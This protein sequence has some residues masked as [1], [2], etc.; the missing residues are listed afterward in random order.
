MTT[1]ELRLTTPSDL[2]RRVAEKA[3]D[4]VAGGPGRLK[5]VALLAGVLALAAA[6]QGAVSAVSKQLETAFS[7]SNTQFG[8]ILSVVTF[9]GAIGTIPLGVLVDRTR[10]RR[11]LIV[12]I[13]VWAAAMILSSTA[14]SYLYFLLTRILLGVVTAAAWPA[15]ASLTGDFFPARERA[16]LYGLIVGGEL[17]GSG[18]GFFI[19]GEVGSFANWRWSFVAMAALSLILLFAVWRF[20]P[21]PERGA[22]TW[23]GQDAHGP[24]AAPGSGD[25]RS[26]QAREAVRKSGVEPRKALILRE[27]PTRRSLLWAIRYCLR[28]PTYRLLV[29]AS[30][31]AYYFFSGVRAFG[32]IYF[33]GHFGLKSGAVSALV[34]VI[35]LG[36]LA[37]MIGG[38]RLSERL[39]ARGRLDARVVLPAIAL[40]ASVP[41]LGVG[42]WTRSVWLGLVCLT[43]GILILS[44]AVAPIDAARLDVVVP[45]LWGRAEA[46]RMALRS[47]FEGSAPLVFGALSGWI[48][49]GNPDQGLEWT[50]LLMLTPMVLASLLV[51][52][53]R[54]TYPRDVATAAASAS[55]PGDRAG[56][57]RL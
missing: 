3:Q 54:K 38:G 42:I 40:I 32:M 45:Q 28:I 20:L 7:L 25:D 11:V 33:T 15:V 2:F 50:F 4:V 35:G 14:T 53:G 12:A 31:L 23:L 13:A 9:A 37:G 47:T 55:V 36:A 41:I 22:Q 8:L 17:V 56:T 48:G 19:S 6:D 44:A 29:I 49:G 34:F 18:V 5:I 57:P 21:E 24:N 46:G 26:G 43:I 51:F 27:D 39:L 16:R 52:P 1:R 30:A 10:R